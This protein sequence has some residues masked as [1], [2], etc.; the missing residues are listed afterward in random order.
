[1]VISQEAE[2]WLIDRFEQRQGRA[3]TPAERE[4]LIARHV[5]EEVLYREGL[6]L[7]LDR[8]DPIVR[9]RVVQRMQL[10]LDDLAEPTDDQLHEFF[11][12]HADAYAAPPTF[13]VEHVYF[14]GV[15]AR[16]RAEEA[17]EALARGA[18]PSALGEPFPHGNALRNRTPA[19][20]AGMVGD[21]LARVITA[22]ELGGWFV[23]ESSLGWHALRVESREAG[24]LPALDLVR[25]RVVQDWR[26]SRARAS[27]SPAIA[28]LRARY[29]VD[30]EG[31]R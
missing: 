7:G 14:T 23:G 5:D 17:R 1:V 2:A 16:S 19:Q 15:D 31:V 4:E 10:L 3:P 8:S 22:A 20:L 13:V 24:A 25:A 9:R 11:E 12:A 6:A 21:D 26:R 28:S 18:D 29:R 27:V 30:R